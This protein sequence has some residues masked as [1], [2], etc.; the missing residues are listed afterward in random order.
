MK[1]RMLLVLTALI[2]GAA[3]VA[4]RVSTGTMGPFSF[5]GLR[6]FLGML[7]VLPLAFWQ[8]KKGRVGLLPPPR[9]LTFFLAILACGTALFSGNA[10]QQ[11]ALA[12][13]T[14]GKAGFI[15]ALYIILVPLLGLAFF[16]HPLRISHICGC[17]I[18]VTGL[19]FLAMHGDGPLN[20]GD[21][22]SFFASICWAI[23]ILIL[24]YFVRYYRGE[25]LACGQFFVC[26]LL[27]FLVIVLTGEA[28]SWD[29]IRA[30][31]GPI[32]FAGILSAGVAYTLQVIAQEHVPPTETSLLLSLEMIF[33]V[34]AEYVFLGESMTFRE[35]FGCL[36]MT[37]G[38]VAAQLPG[39][40]I[41]AR[42]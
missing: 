18:A 25:R 20:F 19:Y 26:A 33:T 9:H 2:W 42:K 13:T 40:I 37:G 24:S 23:H 16:R 35:I 34:L 22:L 29:M 7:T 5:N 31:A 27:N 30:T 10:I 39:R 21:I 4:K 6:F 32:L 15:T 36:L 17:V 1:Y 14:A 8:G 41:W 12:Y 38:I 11:V 3:M 28:L